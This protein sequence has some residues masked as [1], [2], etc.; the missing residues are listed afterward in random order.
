M[1]A[2]KLKGVKPFNEF[3]FVSCYY[4][5]LMAAYSCLGVSADK[6]I[7]DHFFVYRYDA[8]KKRLSV[9]HERLLSARDFADVYGVRLVK[10]RKI[11]DLAA[12][13]VRSIDGGCPA[14]VPVDCFGLSYRRDV[15]GKKH[16]PHFI[17]VYGYDKNKGV[18][19]VVDHLYNNDLAYK[20]RT[21][22]AAELCA[23]YDAFQS[24]LNKSAG[25]GVVVLKKTAA[26]KDLGRVKRRDTAAL[27]EKSLSELAKGV[28]A[29]CRAGENSETFQKILPWFVDFVGRV[30]W[31]K[32]SEIYRLDGR[33]RA[34]RILA[35]IVNDYRFIYGMVIRMQANGFCPREG[36]DKITAR[37][38]KI[39]ARERALK[40]GR[41]AGHG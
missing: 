38:K 41:E 8:K 15:Y 13:I 23:A 34:A 6:I 35:D 36:V 24:G 12:E 31:V 10:K 16:R 11:G 39:L 2:K 33:S 5:Q 25:S 20:K 40:G 19:H 37:L 22:D 7:S 27:A 26:A 14:V 30:R 29:V 28:R 17:C 32:F 21:V 9:E 18:F 3:L 4:H 1:K